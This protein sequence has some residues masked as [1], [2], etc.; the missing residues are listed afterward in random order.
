MKCTDFSMNLVLENIMKIEN[1]CCI[2]SFYDIQ[3]VFLYCDGNKFFAHFC[4]TAYMKPFFVCSYE[5][6]G[7]K[8]KTAYEQAPKTGC[9]KNISQGKERERERVLDNVQFLR[10]SQFPLEKN[11]MAPLLEEPK[12]DHCCLSI[13]I[14]NILYD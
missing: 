7:I 11:C 8:L 14:L 2:Q 6:N 1:F 9:K 4:T 5:C 12:A 13:E 3:T 10:R